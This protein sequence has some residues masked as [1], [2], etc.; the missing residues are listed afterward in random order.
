MRKELQR[1]NVISSGDL[2]IGTSQTK[3]WFAFGMQGHR[4][5]EG[6]G[7]ELQTYEVKT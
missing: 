6:C 2:V 7:A 1:G 5:G 4:A 3:A